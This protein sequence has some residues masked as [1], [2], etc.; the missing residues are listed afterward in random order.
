MNSS[1]IRVKLASPPPDREASRFESGAQPAA[2]TQSN[3]VKRFMV[4]RNWRKV[5]CLVKAVV[6]RLATMAVSE[7]YRLGRQLSAVGVWIAGQVPRPPAA[8]LF[9]SWPTLPK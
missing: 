3:A 5:A 8:A 4:R 6:G 1:A 9:A 2:R 7:P